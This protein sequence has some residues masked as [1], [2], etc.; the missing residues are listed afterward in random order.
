MLLEGDRSVASAGGRLV[1]ALEALVGHEA[2][3]AQRLLELVAVVLVDVLG[4][5][6]NGVR[7]RLGFAPRLVVHAVGVLFA[8]ARVQALGRVEEARVELHLATVEARVGHAERDLLAYVSFFLLL[9]LS[10]AKIYKHL[11]LFVRSDRRV[12]EK[13]KY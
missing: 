5:P 13:T 10:S 12:V 2:L 3:G 4:R 7:H 9:Q 1:G 8:E 11:M 6:I